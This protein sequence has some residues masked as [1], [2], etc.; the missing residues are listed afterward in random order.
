MLTLHTRSKTVLKKGN[1]HLHLHILFTKSYEDI[2]QIPVQGAKITLIRPHGRG[3]AIMVK[4]ILSFEIVKGN[5][6]TPFQSYLYKDA[7]FNVM[8]TCLFGP[9]AVRY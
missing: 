7:G 3:V 6:R 9:E 1:L 4:E 2:Q 8:K 5:S